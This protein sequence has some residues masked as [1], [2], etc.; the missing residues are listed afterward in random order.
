MLY[1]HSLSGPHTGKTCREAVYQHHIFTERI[2]G[3]NL[4]T[5]PPPSI[6]LTINSQR[7]CII[8]SFLS[9]FISISKFLFDILRSF[10]SLQ[11]TKFSHMSIRPLKNA[12]VASKIQF[13]INSRSIASCKKQSFCSTVQAPFDCKSC[14]RN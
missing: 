14:V 4:K 2:Q 1:A 11:Q 6:P 13:S 8:L 10:A 7:K 12:R 9:R 5:Q 3:N